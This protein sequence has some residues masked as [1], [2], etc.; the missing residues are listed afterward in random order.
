M[1]TTKNNS[2]EHG[3]EAELKQ[4]ASRDDRRVD[5]EVESGDK[6]DVVVKVGEIDI[7]VDD[8]KG[9]RTTVVIHTEHDEIH[10]SPDHGRDHYHPHHHVERI[11]VNEK[12]AVVHAHELTGLQ[13]KQ[14]A[15]AAGIAIQLQFVLAEER[16]DGTSHIIG[17]E[18]VVKLH[19][20]MRFSAIRDDDNS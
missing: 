4:E 19:N 13:I 17:D 7:V 18:D 15:I 16:P 12:P 5:V 20:D 3:L 10:D 14:A 9:D 2:H 1:E 6:V 8:D 11:F